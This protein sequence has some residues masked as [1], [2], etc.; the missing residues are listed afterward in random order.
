MDA[1]LTT[2][3]VNGNGQHSEAIGQDGKHYLKHRP[4]YPE[5]IWK[6]WLSYHKGPLTSLHDIGSGGGNATEDLL[7]HISSPLRFVIL[8]EPKAV[9]I[10]DCRARFK[11]RF[12][13]TCFVYRKCH[14]EDQWEPPTNLEHV[15]FVMACESIHWTELKPTMDNIAKS[16][17]ANGTFAAVIYA[18]YPLISNNSI[19]NTAFKDFIGGHASWLLEQ[20]WMNEKWQRA[21]RQLHQGL[22]FLPLREDLWTDVRRININIRDGWLADSVQ[23]IDGPLE[24]SDNVRIQACEWD[25]INESKDWQLLASVE[26]LKQYLLSLRLGF[27]DRSWT[28]LKWQKIESEV[29]DGNLELV[30]PVQILLARRRE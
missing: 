29:Q 7:R 3:L 10:N 25:T 27:S 6:L 26:W 28:S 12:L 20:G 13:D 15:D 30:W 23:F 14:A 16:L 22:D 24:P 8:T 1:S 2:T 17:R 11:G 19:A 18:P 9:N 4:P 21:A 5:S